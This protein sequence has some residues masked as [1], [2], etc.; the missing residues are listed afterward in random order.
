MTT[1]SFNG[2]PTHVSKKV[3]VR[4]GRL[5]ASKLAGVNDRGG[6]GSALIQCNLRSVS[7]GHVVDPVTPQDV[8]SGLCSVRAGSPEG[9]VDRIDPAQQLTEIGCLFQRKHSMKAASQYIKVAP[10]QQANCNEFVAHVSLS[11]LTWISQ[12]ALSC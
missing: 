7:P 8:D 1:L 11:V 10:R 12:T 6:G 2:N 3:R 9:T 5:L 4:V